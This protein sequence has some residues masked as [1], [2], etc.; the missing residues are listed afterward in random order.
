MPLK[1]NAVSVHERIILQDTS[2]MFQIHSISLSD[3]KLGCYFRCMQNGRPNLEDS[4]G[5]KWFF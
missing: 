5:K 1:F 3:I 2:N 4:W